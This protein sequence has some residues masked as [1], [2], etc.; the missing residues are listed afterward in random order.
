MGICP[1][2]ARER[3]RKLFEWSQELLDDDVLTQSPIS[4]PYTGTVTTPW[5][6]PVSPSDCVRWPNSPACP[7]GGAFFDPCGIVPTPW[8]DDVERKCSKDGCECCTYISYRFLGFGGAPVVVCTR[9]DT[10][11]C[12]PQ[13]PGIP[14]PPGAPPASP[15]PPIPNL[16]PLEAGCSYIVIVMVGVKYN[17]PQKHNYDFAGF[18]FSQ[19]HNRD[20]TAFG[21][22]L[23]FHVWRDFWFTNFNLEYYAYPPDRFVITNRFFNIKSSA[24]LAG[25]LEYLYTRLIY[26]GLGPVYDLPWSISKIYIACPSGTRPFIPDS[27]APPYLPEDDDMACCEETNDKLEEIL[28]RLGTCEASIP[29]KLIGDGSVIGKDGTPI[30]AP[31]AELTSLTDI[32]EFLPKLIASRL[33]TGTFPITVPTSLLSNDGDKSEKKLGNLS[34]F[35]HWFVLQFDA[36]VGEFPIKFE[37][38]DADATKEGDQKK[39]VKLPNLAEAIAELY[40]LA[41][42]GGYNSSI[43]VD[44][45]IRAI[46]EIIKFG[47]MG[48]ETYDYAK[49][50]V[51]HLAFKGNK[52][53]RTLPY[54]VDPR[55]QQDIDKFR[56]EVELKTQGYEYEDKH[57]QGE[58]LKQLLYVA[59]M[60]KSLFWNEY[61]PKQ[62]HLDGKA[63]R[64]D[65]K[66][67]DTDWAAYKRQI[68]NP[69][70]ALRAKD[71]P[72]VDIKEVRKGSTNPKTGT[73]GSEGLGGGLGGGANS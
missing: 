12:R 14:K 31:D 11:E 4:Y 65:V 22:G 24:G 52:V 42:Q 13:P 5:T 58:Q 38:T 36:L 47:N 43:A 66:K 2:P 68:E 37:I 63:V 70:S 32:V 54:A 69:N 29:G 46:A 41:F 72:R 9:K 18:K 48:V 64:E 35:I 26:S 28:K 44:L 56:K 51:K 10:P 16:P 60:L 1:P 62:Q 53:E 55:E 61:N 25:M 39:E 6:D 49:A 71:D 19:K 27:G 57:T 45:Q 67:E 3:R 34:E 8:P 30:P 40:G 33:G 59:T 50:I 23:G 7:G 15:Y 17:E 20:G 73:G 21:L